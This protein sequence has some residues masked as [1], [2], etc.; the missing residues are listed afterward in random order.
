[1]SGKGNI[2]MSLKT[3]FIHLHKHQRIQKGQSKKNPEKLATQGLS[4]RRKTKQK[5][6]KNKNQNKTKQNKKDKKKPTT[7]YVGHHFT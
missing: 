4:R 1:M 5:Q 2:R 3:D 7:I 6:T